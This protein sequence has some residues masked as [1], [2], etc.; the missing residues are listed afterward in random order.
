MSKIIEDLN[1]RYATKKFDP[2][3]KISNKDI[4]TIKESLRLVP[5]SY[6]LQPLKYLL[7]ESPEIRDQLV[8]ASYG[9]MQV[10]DAS[11]LIVLCSLINVEEKH[12][13]EYMENIA[14][15]RN[16]QTDS[17]QLFSN[18]IKGSIEKMN[19]HDVVTWTEK[20]AYIALGQLMHTCATMR[21]DAT[22]MEGF[23][24][25]AYDE[26]LNLSESNLKATLVCPIGYRHQE[27]EAQHRAKVR[28]SKE[29][30]FEVR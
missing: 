20:Q 26:I 17:L 21:I 16:V 27:D 29:S 5:S 7:I 9:Q 19:T 1:W 25:K 12:V 8:A 30:I 13:D 3:K 24:P 28:K 2:T 22:P 11:H 15:T 23:D 14:H 18:T 10:K 6:G 4:E